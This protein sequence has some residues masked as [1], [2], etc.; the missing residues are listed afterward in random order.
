VTNSAN[1][2]PTG[3]RKVSLLFSTAS[4]STVNTSSHVRNISIKTPCV[5]DVVG[6]SVVFTALMSPGNMHDT[7]PAATMPARSCV[8]RKMIP[9]VQGS[10]PARHKP[11]VTCGRQP[12][13]SFNTLLSRPSPLLSSIPPYPYPV[14]PPLPSNMIKQ[15]REEKKEG[16]ILTAG[17]NNPPLIR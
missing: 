16:R 17:L 15:Q 4:I 13:L 1:P 11:N 6:L 14:S 2:T 9:R 12:V 7:R 8:G 3:A 5:I 10:L